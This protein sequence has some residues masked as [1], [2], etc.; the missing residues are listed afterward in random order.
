MYSSIR[1]MTLALL[2][3]ALLVPFTVSVA[4]AHGHTE[5]G[6]YTLVI[7]FHNEPAYQGEP[8]G[9]D[10]FVTNT[11]T[12][13]NINGLADTLNVEIIFGSSKK[14]LAI[15]PQWGRDGA[16]TAYVL[17]SEKGDY[18]WH[19]TGDIKGT[20]VDVSM[21]SSPD[22]FGSVEAKSEVAFPAAE[23]TPAELQAQ[24]AAAAQTAQMAL[25]VGA[26]GAALGVIGIAV[27]VLG[28]RARGA[29][30]APAASQAKQ[31]A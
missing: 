4:T 31:T 10:L 20:P 29:A 6:D 12:K 17:P 30:V 9:L 23:A 27:G 11:K 24:A 1:R 15:K 2:L 18:T 26:L 21:T 7:G 3:A 13:E 14:A 19:I 16:Y 8:N 22:T 5:V 28:L 25:I